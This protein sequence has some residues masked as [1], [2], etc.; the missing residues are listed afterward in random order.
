MSNLEKRLANLRAEINYH[1]YRYH[2]LDDPVISD[3]E[4][5]QLMNELRQLEMAHPETLTSDSPTQRVGTEPLEG[6]EK[7]IHTGQAEIR[8]Y[9]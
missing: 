7:V 2:T 9:F 5:D 6:F 1:L 3:A 8:A 4:Y